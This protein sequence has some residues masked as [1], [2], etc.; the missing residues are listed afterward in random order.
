M[1]TN[2]QFLTRNLSHEEYIIHNKT[3]YT[4]YPNEKKKLKKQIL[5][6]IEKKRFKSMGKYAFKLSN[7]N[8]SLKAN[9]KKL[10]DVYLNL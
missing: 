6:V 7:K 9:S 2:L 8:F 10:E 5:N 4:Y 1:R 3:G